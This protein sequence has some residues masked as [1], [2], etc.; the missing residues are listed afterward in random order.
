MITLWILC[1]V[2]DT[3]EWTMN[4][5]FFCLQVSSAT[6]PMVSMCIRI[7]RAFVTLL[8]ET[9]RI[10]QGAAVVKLYS[11]V[12]GLSIVLLN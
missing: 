4:L 2:D 7:Q 9:E 11:F 5:P 6:K 12:E 10:E 8:K 3:L 1:K